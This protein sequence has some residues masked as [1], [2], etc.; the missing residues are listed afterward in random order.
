M[1]L[2]TINSVTTTQILCK[3]LQNL[4]VF[5]ATVI[6]DINKTH[7][8]FDKNHSQLLAHGATVDNSIGPLF[9]A[10]LV[11]SCH[12]FKEYIRCYH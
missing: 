5:A 8:K 10:Y 1:R 9:E 6:D 12:T 11:V 3:T 2:S 4:G 7:G